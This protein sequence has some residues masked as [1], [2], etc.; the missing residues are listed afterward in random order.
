MADGAAPLSAAG[1]RRDRLSALSDDLL[2]QIITQHLPVTEAAKTAALARRWR[3]LWSS[4]PLVL[5][6]AALPEPARD[7]LVP[8]VLAKHEG[9]FRTVAL[10]DLRLASLDR[11]LPGWPRLVAAKH[12]Q[13]LHLANRCQANDI[14]PLVPADILRCGSLEEL[15]L[16]SWAFPVDLSRGAGVS[17]PNLRQLTLVTAAIEDRDLKHL[18]TA[19]TALEILKLAGTTAN[20]IHLCSPSL[21]CA[22]VML[23]RDENLAVVD[24]P[25]LE[26]L[27]LFLPATPAM[28]KIDHAANLRVLGH[29]D[30]RRLHRLQIR[31]TLIELNTMASTTTA[32]PSV[33]ILAVTVNFVILREVKMLASFLRCFPNID[34]LH[35]EYGAS[36]QLLAGGKSG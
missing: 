13:E 23:S 32:I 30:T 22:L 1:R 10:H 17:L 26:R 14:L 35:I 29:L 7:A 12:T 31:D 36:C 9:H 27:V 15:M 25:L 11:E 6:D 5:R 24:A 8:R 33:R 2:H 3:H 21:R 19:C 28:V 4:T 20:R 16:G 18:I 34:T